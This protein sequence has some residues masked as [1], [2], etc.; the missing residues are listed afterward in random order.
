MLNKNT[1]GVKKCEHKKNQHLK[2]LISTKA[3][4][5]SYLELHCFLV[6]ILHD[7]L[8]IAS[9]QPFRKLSQVVCTKLITSY[10][11]TY[12]FIQIMANSVNY[13]EMDAAAKTHASA[14]E[15]ISLK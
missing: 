6:A 5:F 8:A 15:N 13:E 11:A 2:A 10:V 4:K 9:V 3:K 12:R 14:N 7:K 1:P